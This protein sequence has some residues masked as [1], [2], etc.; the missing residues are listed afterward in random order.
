MKHLQC[1]HFLTSQLCENAYEINLD[2]RLHQRL[3][4]ASIL[5]SVAYEATVELAY[6]L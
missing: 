2:M 5:N 1:Q 3:R 6:R 4:F